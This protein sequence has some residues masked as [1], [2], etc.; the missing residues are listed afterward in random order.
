MTEGKKRVKLPPSKLVGGGGGGR[1]GGGERGEK[2]FKAQDHPPTPMW[3]G[4][5]RGEKNES[6]LSAGKKGGEK[7]RGV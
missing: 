1:F 2:I 5:Q 3:G 7:K 4:G 6:L